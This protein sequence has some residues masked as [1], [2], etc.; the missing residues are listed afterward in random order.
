MSA[1]R[2]K[3]LKNIFYSKGCAMKYVKISIV[4]CSING[5]A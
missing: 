4:D 5:A 3:L 1:A 2:A